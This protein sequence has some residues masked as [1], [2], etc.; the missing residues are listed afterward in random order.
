MA[1]HGLGLPF[2]RRK[3]REYRDRL[4]AVGD[5]PRIA[6]EVFFTPHA[7]QRQL[8]LLKERAASLGA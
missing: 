5:H 4:A 8:R 2:Y 6:D 1:Y 3:R 7:Q